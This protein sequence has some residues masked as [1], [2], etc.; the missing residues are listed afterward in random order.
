MGSIPNFATARMETGVAEFIP[1]SAHITPNV[2]TTKNGDL[3]TIFR[4]RG[5]APATAGRKAV[6]AW[7]DQIAAW[8]RV[9]AAPNLAIWTHTIRRK[10]DRFPSGKADNAF[11]RAVQDKYEKA[12]SMQQ[13]YS[14]EL[15]VS[16]V[17]RPEQGQ[18]ANLFS[19]VW[20]KLVSGSASAEDAY[21]EQLR[22][23]LEQIRQASETTLA[24]L[25]MYDID[26]LGTY[27]HNG[28]TFS[29][30]CEFL[31]FLVNGR[32]QKMPLPR[33]P[34]HAMLPTVAPYFARSGL[35]ALAH[36][37]EH[38]FA[39]CVSMR[40]YPSAT[41]P[42]LLD[43]IMNVKCEMVVAQSFACGTQAAAREQI[44][45]QLRRL[46]AAE[47]DGV[48]QIDELAH[49]LNEL[50]SN[51]V[52][53]GYHSFAVT[54]FEDDERQLNRT[55]GTLEMYLS[56]AGMKG[57]FDTMTNAACF[58]STL[59]GNFEFRTKTPLITNYNFAGLSSFHNEA[60]G[61]LDG[62]QWGEA[63]TV[64][65]TENSS[66]F[67]FSFHAGKPG[68]EG[69]LERL[70]PEHKDLA[71]TVVIGKSGTGKTVL[72]MFL[73]ASLLKLDGD[74]PQTRLT[75]VV[76][77][78]DL[79]ASIA[80]RALGGRYYPLRNG[81]RSG[82]NPF[83]LP[84]TPNNISFL[85]ALVRVLIRGRDGYELTPLEEIQVDKAIRAVMAT[86]IE[87][88][89]LACVGE[90]FPA[91]DNV[92]LRLAKWIGGG[93]LAWLFDNERDTLRFDASVVGF[94][95][96]EFLENDDTRTPTIFYLLHRVENML[97]GRRLP[98]FMDEFWK[99]LDD[100]MFEKLIEN[101]L[102]T[103]RKQNGFL[104]MFSQSPEQ[105]ARSKAA[106]AVVGQTATKI[107]LPNPEADE[108]AYIE[109][110]RLTQE[111]VRAIKGLGEKSRKMLIKQNGNSVV[112]GLNLRNMDDELAV[113]S[114]NTATAKLCDQAI[115]QVGDDPGAW[116]PL[117][118]KMR[119]EGAAA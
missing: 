51:N 24:A 77:D 94:D 112:V 62:N 3:V 93:E 78:K 15:Y 20:N 90:R 65:E 50:A 72:E 118:H 31:G 98:I 7:A 114:G 58:Y 95:V 45:I 44:G 47:D 36:G 14:N 37:P 81:V 105:V 107:M 86:P 110:F 80:V 71:N 92:S 111:E 87:R 33:G 89:N 49:A 17:V 101:K 29:E 117:F 30:V 116:L 54:V 22:V 64:F 8:V 75:G 21:A 5:R 115:A 70:D 74:T 61:K 99:L 82:F 56:N 66:P 69:R 38:R 27:E 34:I 9:I 83:S 39:N 26:T 43:G 25:D 100:P 32:W 1:Y 79:G 28:A 97:D 19:S 59:P 102:V 106:Y 52:V 119:K 96:T 48:T 10:D 113:L 55:R 41:R 35:I 46:E 68:R 67:F 104:A 85:N 4:L 91:S 108:R 23:L 88:R 42:G 11:A 84:P 103:I 2:I 40:E 76:F 12:M 13:R 53:F 18:K 63:V 57:H 109:G 16:L 73:M 60:N 6:R